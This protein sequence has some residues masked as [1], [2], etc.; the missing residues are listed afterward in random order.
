LDD[1]LVKKKQLEDFESQL[2]EEKLQAFLH[3]QQD[4][5]FHSAKSTSDGEAT[6]ANYSSAQNTSQVTIN[7]RTTVNHSFSR[8]SEEEHSIEFVEGNKRLTE[9]VKKDL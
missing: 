2:R 7:N 8:K 5:K 3:V 9:K 1:E 6:V 4:H